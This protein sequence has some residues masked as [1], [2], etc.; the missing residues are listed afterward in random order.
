MKFA[1]A[2]FHAFFR[3][4]E[5][6]SMLCIVIMTVVVFVDVV[7]R[8]AFQSG[9]SWSQE[10]ATLMM[11][12]FGFLGIAIGVLEKL[13]MSIEL[14]TMKLPVKIITWIERIDYFVISVFGILMVTYGVQIMHITSRATMPATKMPSAVLYIILPLAGILIA[15]NGFIVASGKNEK[16]LSYMN[17]KAKEESKNG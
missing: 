17:R 15:L 10:I 4:L 8:Y 6:F 1:K 7:L 11:V 12:W 13:H 9:F 14:F 3:L 16:I 2:C 5:S